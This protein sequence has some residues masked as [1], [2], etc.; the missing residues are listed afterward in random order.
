MV[1]DMT[2][3]YD[4]PGLRRLTRTLVHSR[5]G[6]G[7]VEVTDEFSVTKPI[8]V[9]ESFPT[10]GTWQKIDDHT[11]L[12]MSGGKQLWVTIEG[13]NPVTFAET[14]V[15]EYGNPFTRITAQIPINGSGKI[16]MRFSP[17][18]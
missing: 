5:D 2:R 15:D 17:E 10:H 4:A 1:I 9:I 8:E 12:F 7:A 18:D 11:M 13:P 16:I 3:A 14:K 6:S